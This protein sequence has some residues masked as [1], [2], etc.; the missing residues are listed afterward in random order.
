MRLAERI[1]HAN[2]EVARRLTASRARWVDVRPLRD[3]VLDL[4]AYELTHSGPPLLWREMGGAQRGAVIAAVLFE[5]WASTPSEARGCSTARRSRC[6]PTTT[7]AASG[8]APAWA[9][10]PPRCACSR[11]AA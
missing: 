2:A 6:A 5:G 8:R 3:V 9:P 4:G 11:S 1:D 7:R 10:P